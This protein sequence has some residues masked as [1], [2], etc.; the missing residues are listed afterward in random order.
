M[1]DIYDQTRLM[2][3]D[4]EIPEE[5]PPIKISIDGKSINYIVQTTQWNG[6]GNKKYNA[7]REI[8]SKKYPFLPLKLVMITKNL[9]A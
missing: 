9:F 4:K 2:K 3:I 5:P 7:F 8:M 1:G 6:S